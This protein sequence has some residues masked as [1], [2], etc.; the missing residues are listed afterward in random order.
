MMIAPTVMLFRR[1]FTVRKWRK[2]KKKVGQRGAHVPTSIFR[3]WKWDVRDK[4]KE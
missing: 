4:G 2:I 1:G 3:P